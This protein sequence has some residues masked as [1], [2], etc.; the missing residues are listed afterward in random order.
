A[1]RPHPHNAAVGLA[2]A[3]PTAPKRPGIARAPEPPPRAIHVD[4]D[5]HEKRRFLRKPTLEPKLHESTK[6]LHEVL[7][8]SASHGPWHARGRDRSSRRSRM[9][10]RGGFGQRGAG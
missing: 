8:S 3:S 9:L 10:V 1:A 5:V 7:P 4:F 2:R 6:T